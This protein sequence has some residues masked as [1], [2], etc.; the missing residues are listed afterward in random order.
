MKRQVCISQPFLSS[1]FSFPYL[2]SLW[3][4]WDTTTKIWFQARF[5]A[6][7]NVIVSITLFWNQHY[8]SVGIFMKQLIQF[9]PYAALAA[10]IWIFW[11]QRWTLCFLINLAETA[12][13]F[14][15]RYA[16]WAGGGGGILLTGLLKTSVSMR[17][18]VLSD[19][20]VL[21]QFIDQTRQLNS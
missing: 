16:N 19:R 21:F 17:R 11:R 3:G 20:G 9:Q 18:N 13:R 10:K 2:T 1:S 4:N 14:L 5:F 8:F 12:C 7:I 6:V 15:D